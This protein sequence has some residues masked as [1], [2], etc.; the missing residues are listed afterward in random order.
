MHGAELEERVLGAALA[1]AVT[2][3]DRGAAVELV[4]A[5]AALGVGDAAAVALK[6]MA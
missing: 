3:E 5:G 2:K 4:Q 6:E 1:S